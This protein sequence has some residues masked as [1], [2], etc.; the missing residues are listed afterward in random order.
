MNQSIDLVPTVACPSVF[1][2]YR[3]AL[4]RSGLEELRAAHNLITEVPSS[5]GKNVALRTLDLGHNTI[6][7]WGGLERVG[8]SLSSLVQITLA[9][10]P[11]C[12]SAPPGMLFVEAVQSFLASLYRTRYQVFISERGDTREARARSTFLLF[13]QPTTVFSFSSS[14]L[15]SAHFL[16]FVSHR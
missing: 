16:F 12:G 11:L 10:N 14:H 3:D 13:C 5:L 4:P 2:S 6:E 9:G 8:K 15:F 1:F 7:G